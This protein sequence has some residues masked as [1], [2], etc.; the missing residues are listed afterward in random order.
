MA[1]TFSRAR[2]RPV[3]AL[4]GLFVG[5]HAVLVAAVALLT[6]SPESPP[7]PARTPV[8]V[9]RTAP[10][11]PA[12]AARH[13]ADD[14][15]PP[16]L[17]GTA[18]VAT[19]G[20]PRPAAPPP[21]PADDEDEMPSPDTRPAVRPA[22]L[23]PAPRWTPEQM[24]ASLL[25]VP[26][27]WL[28]HPAVPTVPQTGKVTGASHPVLTLIDARPDLRGLPARRG[29][30]ARLPGP[31]AD[32]LRDASVVLR[33]AI[34]QMIGQNAGGNKRIVIRPEVLAARPQVVAR[35]LHQMLQV[36]SV[37]LRTNL[38][39]QLKQLHNPASSRAL[40]HRAVYEPLDDMR[41]AALR[42]LADRPAVDYLPVLLD[43]LGSPWP[44]AADHA[45]D[46]L[47]AL[48]PAGAVPELVRRLDAPDPAAPVRDENGGSVVHELVR[49]NHARNCLLCHAQSVS[50]SDG[51]RVAVPNPVRPLPSPFS[52]NTY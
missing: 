1:A 22:G 12:P 21:P 17:L 35:L 8:T 23:R 43:A 9:T 24:Q 5:F 45:A 30:D 34:S 25:R 41:Q 51:V 26:E 38:L 15:M 50:V 37:S 4:I 27:V 6:R 40:A 36:E 44:P 29:P 33:Q 3:A 28:Q 10:A 13:D 52:L 7:Q 32:A 16:Y 31:D 48:A 18:P 14:E 42:V 20:P 46:T 39:T 49:V 47:A 19:A 2:V 11:V